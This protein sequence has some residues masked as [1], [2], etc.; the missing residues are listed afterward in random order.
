MAT[1][2]D[3]AIEWWNPGRGLVRRQA[4]ARIESLAKARMLYEGASTGRRSY[5][6]R[7]AATDANAEIA[8]AKVRLRAISRDMVRNNPL[9]ARAVQVIDQNVIGAG[10]V[11]T[12]KSRSEPRAERIRKLIKRHLETTAFDVFG[13]HDLYGVQGLVTRCLVE[14]GEVLVRRLWSTNRNLALPFQVQVLEPD[15]LDSTVDG[16]LANGNT[17]RQGI[18][19]DK[20]GQRAAYHLY[21]NHPGSIDAFTQET[22]RVPARDIIHVFRGDRAGQER[23][24]TWFHPVMVRMKDLADFID[25]QLMR[26]KIAACFAAFVTSETGPDGTLF[27]PEK[28]Q[29]TGLPIENVAPGMVE[30]LRPGQDVKFGG[31]PQIGDFDPYVRAT[32][33]E[34]ATGVGITY[35]ALTGDHSQ[36]NYSSGRMGW[37]EF[38]RSIDLW[39]WRTIIPKLCNGIAEW[40]LEAV[41]IMAPGG[42]GEEASIEWT[43]PKREMLKPSEEVP[44][45]RDAI[46]SGLKSW[47]E[48][49]R[50]LG[51]DPQAVA[52]EISEDQK[53]FDS[54]GLKLDSDGRFPMTRAVDD[55]PKRA[56]GPSAPNEGNNDA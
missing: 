4:R 19:Y 53:L 7:V 30:Y 27:D 39:R 48:S 10:I 14:S 9:A 40:T 28:D 26:Q 37:I 34:I 17:A 2:L 42:V 52:R 18:E 21:R 25:A 1:I 16:Q 23:G 55:D 43:P 8:G 41:G 36:V 11:P 31:P 3:R 45:A 56:A 54:L 38:Q 12:V 24:V 15:F 35:E 5:G 49:V 50:E 51:Q 46:R 47:S 22:I 20:G 13:Q 44:T 33:R 6:W 29:D 32:Q